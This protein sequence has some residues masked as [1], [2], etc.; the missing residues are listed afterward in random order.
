MT[1]R[2]RLLLVLGV[3]LGAAVLSTGKASAAM[4]STDTPAGPWLGFMNVFN[5]DR[6]GPV[7]VAADFVFPSGWGVGDLNASF[8][9]PNVTLS[10]NTIGDPDPFWYTPSGGPGS[11]G[12]K[13]ME[14][15][16]YKQVDDDSLSGTTV[17]FSAN[18]LSN[19]FTANHTA[20]AFIRDFAPD[21]SSFTFSE[22]LLTPGVFSISLATA[23]GPG[24]H[25]QFGFQVQ[26]ENVWFTEV[27]PFGSATIAPVPEPSSAILSLVGLAGLCARRRRDS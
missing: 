22:T 24:R 15:N 20:K 9:G 5:I 19:T 23:A 21:F 4:V 1:S 8:A 2:F 12:N 18:V 26:G 11:L 6:S 13:W 25:V 27:A 3:A 16:L 17:T 7:P 14:A 10:P